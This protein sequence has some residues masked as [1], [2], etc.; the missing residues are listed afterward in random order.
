[1]NSKCDMMN[2]KCNVMNSKCDMNYECFAIQ[3]GYQQPS[4]RTS[5]QPSQPLYFFSVH[6]AMEFMLKNTN[7]KIKWATFGNLQREYVLINGKVY[8]KYYLRDFYT[9]I[10][11]VKNDGTIGFNYY[12]PSH[13]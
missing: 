9:S 5:Q 2:H 10:S 3:N 1:M 4:Q 12:K 6:D 13:R 7:A 11:Y 8:Y